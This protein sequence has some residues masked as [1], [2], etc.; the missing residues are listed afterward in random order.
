MTCDTHCLFLLKI[1]VK[2]PQTGCTTL[3]SHFWT[4]HAHRALYGV[5]ESIILL[6]CIAFCCVCACLEFSLGGGVCGEILDEKISASEPSRTKS[7]GVAKRGARSAG[8]PSGAAVSKSSKRARSD[9]SASDPSEGIDAEI[10]FWM[11]GRV[12]CNTTVVVLP[13]AALRA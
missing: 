10:S 2:S 1:L 6:S 9:G 3:C 8:P 5:V 7:N 11:Q 13:P 4:Q 12:C